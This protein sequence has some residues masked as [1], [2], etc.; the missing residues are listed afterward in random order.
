MANINDL[1]AT[2]SDDAKKTSARSLTGTAKLTQLASAY[3]DEFIRVANTDAIDTDE[4]QAALKNNNELDALLV[5]TLGFDDFIDISNADME[6]FLELG[7]A[8]GEK[9]LKSQQSKRSRLKSKAMTADNFRNILT[10]AIAE[11]ILRYVFGMEK[12]AGTGAARHSSLD[13][14]DEELEALAADQ[15]ALKKAIRN[16]QSKKSIMKSKAG[17]DPS[18]EQWQQLLEAETRLKSYREKTVRTHTV[19][20][21]ET[22]AALETLLTDVDVSKMNKSQLMEL[23]AG[24]QGLTTE[25]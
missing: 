7:R 8:N 12:N 16:V 18:S 14:T 4:L 22:K 13:Y 17:F 15:T 1:F 25:A 24:I 21:D 23:I 10:A 20:V 19:K 6:F 2:T 3:A 11:L 5:G 9:M